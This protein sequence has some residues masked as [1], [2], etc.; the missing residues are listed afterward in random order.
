MPSITVKHYQ[1]DG[2]TIPSLD[3]WL[4]ISNGDRLQTFEYT[5][6]RPQISPLRFRIYYTGQRYKRTIP[7]FRFAAK[8]NMFVNARPGDAKHAWEG[9]TR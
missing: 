9:V 5:V 8:G 2:Y 6:D 7:V 3:D 1:T 4:S